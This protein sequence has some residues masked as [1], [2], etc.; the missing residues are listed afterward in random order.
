[1]RHLTWDIERFWFRGIVAGERA[2]IAELA[3]APAA[4]Q[5][6]ADLPA[7]AVFAAYRRE[8]ALANAIIAATPLDAAPAW[9]PGD[10]FGDWRLHTLREIVLHVLTETACPTEIST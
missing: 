9:W 3:A 6:D 8:I 5:V 4:W 2:V 7:S 1:M 10:L